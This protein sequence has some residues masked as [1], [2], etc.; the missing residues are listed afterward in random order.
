MSYFD[1]IQEHVMRTGTQAQASA[2]STAHLT[3]VP[4]KKDSGFNAVLSSIPVP[5]HSSIDGL[6][7]KLTARNARH[8][9]T[10][11]RFSSNL[12]PTSDMMAVITL[13]NG[14]CLEDL[15]RDFISAALRQSP[16]LDEIQNLIGE[17]QSVL[18][19]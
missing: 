7:F 11:V 2:P 4:P 18:C 6:R 16:C 17:L 14:R 13:L 1:F 19:E 8:Y 10:D 12:I 15:D 5:E 3:F 9:F